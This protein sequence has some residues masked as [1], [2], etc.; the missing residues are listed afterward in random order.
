[1]S[2]I[3]S[4]KQA[5]ASE[6]KAKPPAPASRTPSANPG[7]PMYVQASAT[8]A[9]STMEKGS[10]ADLG[11]PQ[12]VAAA[13]AG[14][15]RADA[16]LPHLDRIQAAFG[17]HDVSHVRTAT[18]GDAGQAARSMGAHAYT[19]GDR[20]A[21][22]SEPDVRLAAHEAAHVVQQRAGV[23]LK[24]RV[25]RPGDHYERQADAAAD[26]VVEGRSAQHLLGPAKEPAQASTGVQMA[27][28]CGGTCSSCSGGGAMQQPAVQFELDTAAT[29]EREPQLLV[30]A[31][32]GGGAAAVHA[33]GG[34]TATHEGGGN[35]APATA[36]A[37][38]GAGATGAPQAGSPQAAAA[39]PQAAGA[40]QQ[41]QSPADAAAQAE[42]DAFGA[43]RC[44]PDPEP[45]AAEQHDAQ[46]DDEGP[47]HD[48]KAEQ[49][50]DPQFQDQNQSGGEQGGEHTPP[51][52]PPPADIRAQP[53]RSQQSQQAE[54][55][56][57][58]AHPQAGAGQ[59]QPAAPRPP[60]GCEPQQAQ[61]GGGDQGAAAQ[62]RGGG[63]GGGGAPAEAEQD[64]ESPLEG[65]VQDAT[66]RRADSVAAFTSAGDSAAE[67]RTRIASAGGEGVR[68]AE[69]ETSERVAGAASIATRGFASMASDTGALADQLSRRIPS[70]LRGALVT[71]KG[72]IA[73]ALDHSLSAIDLEFDS[74]TAAA[75]RAA[76]M[77][78]GA[79]HAQFNATAVQATAATA[80]AVVRVR[81]ATTRT[82]QQIAAAQRTE[83]AA[84][85][86]I[87]DSARDRLI[88]AGARKGA[89]AMRV[90]HAHWRMYK[91]QRINRRDSIMKGHLTDRRADA[92]A[93]A[94]L[95]TAK[96]FRD[97]FAQEAHAQARA[98]MRTKANNC[99]AVY[100][101]AVGAQN[102]VRTG[103]AQ[104]IG[105]LFQ[106][107]GA[108][109][110]QA[111]TDRDTKIAAVNAQLATQLA[112]LTRQRGKQRQMA[113]DTAYVRA[114]MVEHTAHQLAGNL[115]T[116]ASQATSG[117][118]DAIS[119]VRGQMASQRAP[120]DDAATAMMSGLH[121]R[122]RVSLGQL[123]ERVG[124]G[125]GRAI[126]GVLG[127][128][129]RSEAQF[130]RLVDGARDAAMQMSSSFAD[131]MS[132]SRAD[133]AQSGAAARAQYRHQLSQ[134]TNGVVHTFSCA[135]ASVWQSYIQINSSVS[136]GAREQA[137][138]LE[139]NFG[140]QI[141][142]GDSS[143]LVPSI[144][145]YAC[146]AARNER[147][148]WEEVVKIVL[149]IVV[150]IIVSALLGPVV[151]AAVAAVGIAGAAA[152]IV[153]AIIVGAIAG[154]LSSMA[155]QAFDNIAQGRSIGHG[156]GQAALTGLVTGAIGGF[157][158]GV[159]GVFAQAATRAGAS[160]LTRFAIQFATD[161]ATEYTSQVAMNAMAGKGWSS[162]TD[163]NASGFVMAGAMSIGMHAIHG[164]RPGIPEP[165]EPAP[166]AA[167]E[168]P[169]VVERAGQRLAAADRAIRET[170]PVRAVAERA[171]AVIETARAGT[172]RLG[173]AI[174]G[175]RIGQAI[176]GSGVLQRLGRGISRV[177]SAPERAG[178]AIA[179]AAEP[180]LERVASARSRI[181]GRIRAAVGAAP[182]APAGAPPGGTVP[183]PHEA[184]PPA[185]H[186]AAPPP[187]EAAPPPHAPDPAPPTS[188][189]HGAESAPADHGRPAEG[190]PGRDPARG[191][192]LHEARAAER[193]GHPDAPEVAEG[194]VARERTVGD[195][196]VS[197]TKDGR[198]VVCS[199]CGELARLYEPEI[200]EFGLQRE[201]IEIEALSNPRQKAAAAARLHAR[202]VGLRNLTNVAEAGLLAAGHDPTGSLTH[203]RNV[204]GEVG[205]P[206]A[207]VA[208]HVQEIIRT[209]QLPEGIAPESPY[210]QRLLR[211][212]EAIVGP[213]VAPRPAGIPGPTEAT[214]P[215]VVRAKA[216]ADAEIRAG[217]E[218]RSGELAGERAAGG[219]GATIRGAR[220]AIADAA[221]DISQG[222][223]P[224]KLGGQ[225]LAARTNPVNEGTTPTLETARGP[226]N[227]VVES[228]GTYEAI[229]RLANRHAQR[230]GM[231]P[232]QFIDAFIETLQ[233]GRTPR[234]SSRAATQRT[235]AN[236][237][238]RVQRIMFTSEV[239][240]SPTQVS[241][242]AQILRVM[243]AEGSF[244]P[245][246]ELSPTAPRYTPGNP[247]AGTAAVA[248]GS[249]GAPRAVER[250]F[251]AE[252]RENAVDRAA[253]E[254][255]RRHAEAMRRDPRLRNVP[256]DQ[257]R[258]AFIQDIID[259][260]FGGRR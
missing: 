60:P 258:A 67:A 239:I 89:D 237:M 71:V 14:V 213:R 90:G 74:A 184:P 4:R 162:F 186:E 95:E 152:T 155:G 82:V 224:R 164:R 86:A 113:R 207:Q 185:T 103:G 223:A 169:G 171:G 139:Q 205:L 199:T 220:D 72:A 222:T 56:Q 101:T 3:S 117:I 216:G 145:K 233:T 257:L 149:I 80:L 182:A 50:P 38:A 22:R 156:M 63:S 178:K 62:R 227:L 177:T 107:L 88:S 33:A 253:D 194:V 30:A 260:L 116:G 42:A 91:A 179:K 52:D 32:G 53:Q 143:H 238:A 24:D 228:V 212:A 129:E 58:P 148:A 206:E 104:A 16:P 109:L 232:R 174:R 244:S 115:I 130:A 57:D 73:T 146:V 135:V 251:G 246:R 111:R 250:A 141:T 140:Q 1:M 204:A 106:M 70:E 46:S 144:H 245:L 31:G 158:G 161:M 34:A 2:V 76:G 167:G 68:F 201:L 173:S 114:L 160:V 214:A 163:I 170:A 110:E 20:I 27:C 23:Q 59:G 41:T 154:M 118:A 45:Q 249:K 248:G 25:G 99:A 49:A 96:G 243:Q 191:E 6:P 196:T 240:R 77:S 121:G 61:P 241:D 150:A 123:R 21:F 102:G 218:Q 84:L 40:G 10:G 78:R 193:T 259:T 165:G 13:S 208:A 69:S 28:S 175:S 44:P 202:L 126:D 188:D 225:T 79:I 19:I 43:Q 147:P 55:Q 12:I 221:N 97:S 229:E 189:A 151:G 138:G 17:A 7:L 54:Q 100:R 35:T 254:A 105:A 9:P 124:G 136:S 187:H 75:K 217:L 36:A 153:T 18:G 128:A 26:A 29:R 127:H 159:G 131:A 119:N 92:R 219:E 172:S 66:Q 98:F 256:P 134:M 183:T 85:S 5:R 11:G 83:M 48:D 93:N 215:E 47:C 176:E 122:V 195:H 235:V 137:Q 236:F 234:V 180:T 15:S 8:P 125:L 181:A 132:A 112:T 210:G 157:L 197:V 64:Q 192:G 142:G 252:P 230:L 133:A 190:S 247:E 81:S 211:L 94:A 39:G 87:F 198:V 168:R 120:G 108:T 226:R 65:M 209:G 255:F 166:R 203:V 51:P 200:H 242:M 37:G 231:T